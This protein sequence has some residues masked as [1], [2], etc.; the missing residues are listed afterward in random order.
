MVRVVVA[1]FVPYMHPISV[2]IILTINIFA[3]HNQHLSVLYYYDT[4]SVVHNLGQQKAESRLGLRLSGCS[5]LSRAS[6][7]ERASSSA[8]RVKILVELRMEAGTH[9]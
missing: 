1:Q 5:D 7:R 4:I 6:T 9:G 8:T 2:W 3:G